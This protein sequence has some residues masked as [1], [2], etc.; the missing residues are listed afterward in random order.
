MLESDVYSFMHHLIIIRRDTLMAPC[1]FSAIKLLQ[2]KLLKR[3]VTDR[4]SPACLFQLFTES[5]PGP[6]PVKTI[7]EQITSRKTKTILA[8]IYGAGLKPQEAISILTED[9][10]SKSVRVRDSRGNVAFNK[11]IDRDMQPVVRE[12][13]HRTCPT[14]PYVFPGRDNNS[15]YS[16]RSVEKHF[17]GAVTRSRVVLEKFTLH[18]LRCAGLK[19]RMQDSSGRGK[20]EDAN[21]C[22]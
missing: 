12:Y 8:L 5:L 18:T 10:N 20:F 16:I 14:H 7:L 15:H 4:I 3:K 21:G 11:T 19:K 22:D 2:Q 1:A 9:L 13:F 6:D 17:K